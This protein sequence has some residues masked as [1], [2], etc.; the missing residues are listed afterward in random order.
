MLISVAE[1][2]PSQQLL[3]W[4]QSVTDS[5]SRVLIRTSSTLTGISMVD[6]ACSRNTAADRSIQGNLI[7]Y[8]LL[9]LPI[10]LVVLSADVA[11]EV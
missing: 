6:E 4:S 8:M 10:F 2:I 9:Y 7:L 5:T 1:H 11:L 3:E